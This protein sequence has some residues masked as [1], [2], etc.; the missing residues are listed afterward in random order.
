MAWRGSEINAGS[1][2]LSIPFHIAQVLYPAGICEELVF[3]CRQLHI[4]IST[5]V[6]VGDFLNYK[7][8]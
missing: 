1:V 8:R 4:L 2:K 5:F 6:T 7:Q 3:A